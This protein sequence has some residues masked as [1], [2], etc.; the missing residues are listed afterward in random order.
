ML[1]GCTD[2]LMYIKIHIDG[3]ENPMCVPVSSAGVIAQKL[4]K[5]GKTFRLG[6]TV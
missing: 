5:E 1:I 3:I 6:N 2:S 4:E